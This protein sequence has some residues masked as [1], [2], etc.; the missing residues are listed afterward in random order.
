MEFIKQYTGKILK[1]KMSWFEKLDIFLFT[2]NLPLTAFFSLYVIMNIAILPFLGYTL[3]Y[4]FWLLIPTI[5]FFFAPMANDFITYFN[6]IKKMTLFK[7]MFNTFVLY[8][9]MLFVSLKA[10]LLGML[11][12]KAVFIVTPKSSARTTL[13]MAIKE[14]KQEL[15]FALVLTII[16]E[17]LNKSFLPVALIV[18]PAVLSIH[19]SMF[20]N[21]KKAPPKYLAKP[22]KKSK[23]Y[24]P[25]YANLS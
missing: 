9:S 24:Q 13:W 20:A 12:K 11:G 15:I 7:Y 18:T 22:S 6:H 8:G 23:R 16:S 4:P 19:L 1:S 2:Y 21:K 17:L 10:S 3:H 14:N 25:R 5:I